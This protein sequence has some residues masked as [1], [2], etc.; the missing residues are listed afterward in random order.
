[1]WKTK[2]PDRCRTIQMK[3]QIPTERTEQAPHQEGPLASLVGTWIPRCSRDNDWLLARLWMGCTLLS[4]GTTKWCGLGLLKWQP[5]LTTWPGHHPAQ[6]LPAAGLG[7]EGWWKC[8]GSQLGG[9]GRCLLRSVAHYVS[10]P[11]TPTPAVCGVY[12]NEADGLGS[13]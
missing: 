7:E 6:H 11:P 10:P 4:G 9:R 1:M 2:T 13:G 12:W 5:A 3:K 8:S